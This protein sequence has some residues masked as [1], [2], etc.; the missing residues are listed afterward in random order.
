M[1]STSACVADGPAMEIARSPDSRVSMKAS[2]ITVNA[3]NRP[4]ARRRAIRYS[5]SQNSSTEARLRFPAATPEVAATVSPNLPFMQE[6]GL[7]DAR[8]G[9]QEPGLLRRSADAPE[10][11]GAPLRTRPTFAAPRD[12]R[13]AGRQS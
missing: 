4:R 2:V 6:L 5:I 8:V 11:K 1:I 3:T 13:S 9:M 7:L 10:P 12:R